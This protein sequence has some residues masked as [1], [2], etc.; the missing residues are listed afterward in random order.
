MPQIQKPKR[1][2]GLV[3]GRVTLISVLI[4][5]FIGLSSTAATSYLFLKNQQEAFR[6][7]FQTDVEQRV[8]SIQ[9]E[10]QSIKQVMNA[11]TSFYQASK[12]VE[13]SEFQKF[14]SSL[15]T[16][17]DEI[18]GL[19]WVPRI[20]HAWRDS[21]EGL[22]GGSGESL[23]K[24]ITDFEG[25]AAADAAEY[26]PVF[27]AEPQN[28]SELM[29]GRD[30]KLNGALKKLL[31]DVK[32]SGVTRAGLWMDAAS[33]ND[34]TF[35]VATPF[36]R[37]GAE[38]EE[39]PA[40]YLMGS[41]N[42]SA[43]LESSFHHFQNQ[44]IEIF[45][46][47]GSD[48]PRISGV[49]YPA[50]TLSDGQTPVF[51]SRKD[52]RTLLTLDVEGQQWK[53][54][55]YPTA[56]Y[57]EAPLS[58]IPW[59]I[60]F[61]GLLI[62]ALFSGYLWSVYLSKKT[63]HKL[64]RQLKAEVTERHAAEK[65]VR[66]SEGR[67]RQI[68]DLVPQMI[69]ARDKDG[70]F[71]LANKQVADAYGK[72]VEDLI[73][74]RYQDIHL[75]SDEIQRCLRD[76]SVVLEKNQAVTVLEETFTDVH[77]G[78][79]VLQTTKIPYFWND[80][81]GWVVLGVSIDVTERKQLENVR[82]SE[83]RY[84]GV[85]EQSV[86]SILLVTKSGEFVDVNQ[87]ACSTLGYQHQELLKMN[88]FDIDPSYNEKSLA[89]CWDQLAKQK[90]KITES[91][92][93]RKNNSTYPVEVSI[94]R[95]SIRN[96]H[97]L[98]FSARDISQLKRMNR[99]LEKVNTFLDLIF[100]NIPNMVFIKDAKDLRFIRFNKT[101]ADL[102]GVERESMIG[103]NDFDFFPKEEADFFT[104][105]DREVL[106]GGKLVDIPEEPISTHDN[107]VR[108][109]HTKKIPIC[110]KNNKPIYLLGISEDIT[111]QKMA[112]SKLR[113][114]NIAMEN[115]LDGI[116][117]IDKDS[118]Y[119]VVNGAYTEMLGY[120]S[121]EMKRAVWGDHVHPQD[122]GKMKELLSAAQI[123]GKAEGELRALR[124][125]GSLFYEQVVLIKNENEFDSDFAFYCFFKDITEK[126][127]RTSIESKSDLISM[128]SHEL[129]TPLHS[130]REGISV[131][132]DGLVGEISEDQKD[133]LMTNMMS[134]DRLTRLVNSFLD[135][136]RL[137]AGVVEFDF[138]NHNVND[139]IKKAV[140]EI[141]SLAKTKNLQL[142]VDT[143]ESLP[144]VRCDSDRTILVLLNLLGNAIKFTEKG[145]VA[146]SVLLT[147]NSVKVSVKDTGVGI[148]DEEIPRLFQKFGQLE[149]GK[150]I[151]P[152]GTG[153]GLA[154]SR[155]IVEAQHGV[156]E[157]ESDY[158]QGSV[159]SF[160][161][162]IAVGSAQKVIKKVLS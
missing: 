102:I 51:I 29:L 119:V 35:F 131:M 112:L 113:Q 147:G 94:T 30:I 3:S 104:Q 157:V 39:E 77:G 48:D 24:V 56:A 21:Y 20:P 37:S 159:F 105:K 9:K 110:D 89:V 42:V 156:L 160:T 129:R 5:T 123:E 153:L 93:L 13:R 6:A 63:L 125:D 144:L 103:K 152:A 126:K 75:S 32:D 12:R 115:A 98:L 59:A 23:G 41:I 8:I 44:N 96:E 140:M 78:R 28:G 52:F 161:L 100:E 91:F 46:S 45:A 68:V 92:F 90:K 16:D 86:D 136:Q 54:L 61:I 79:R 65:K 74:T 95:V 2:S 127:Y 31:D 81:V 69:Y 139:L 124:K 15:L 138:K 62:T 148:K 154:I 158:N 33:A 55:F 72:K 19:Y 25:D 117:Q 135:F 134:L 60:L 84:R 66:A 22:N 76:D 64:N 121:A 4:V 88:L 114:S 120:T 97:F 111:E 36:Y 73:G 11:L 85:I 130:I 106:A 149:S 43:L 17:N 58:W 70:C 141:E 47:M 26:Y 142:T 162:P 150:M 99:E 71:L 151:A 118:G 116:A 133:I 7:K 122:R 143:D 50:A 145:F 67:I 82:L 27:F 101:G 155:K 108:Y 132:L 40:G 18:N 53:L 146:V 128:V 10:I 87:T 107:Q 83:E 1:V 14:S 49:R 137:E 80:A 109:L 38:S 34:A 57:F